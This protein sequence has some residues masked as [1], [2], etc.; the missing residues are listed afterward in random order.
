MVLSYAVA[1][2]RLTR[3]VAKGVSLPRLQQ[4]EKRYLTHQQ[5][6]E[7]ATR[8]H[9][10]ELVVLFLAYTGMRWVRWPGSGSSASTFSDGEP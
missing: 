9:P 1:D 7:L 2:G 6:H 8:C 10:H 5:V 3:N 4:T